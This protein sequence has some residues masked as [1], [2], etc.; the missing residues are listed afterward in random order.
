MT[1]N[2]RYHPWLCYLAL[3]TL[4]AVLVQIGV[5][6]VV[7][8]IRAGMSD[9]DWPTPPWQGFFP[10]REGVAYRVEQ[11]HRM[12][13]SLVGVCVIALAFGLWVGERRPWLRW[14]GVGAMALMVGT[15]AVGFA[16]AVPRPDN[17]PPAWLG[18]T[19]WFG[20]LGVCVACV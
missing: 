11:T 14:S 20:C 18:P 15:L 2:N 19:L 9:P 13:G 3:A 10:T 6:S 12:T 16:L 4:L 5:G 17:P 1:L 7:T 8:G